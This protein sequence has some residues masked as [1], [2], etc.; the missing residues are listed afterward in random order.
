MT[1]RVTWLVGLD[2]KDDEDW[3]CM[4]TWTKRDLQVVLPVACRQQTKTEIHRWWNAHSLMRASFGRDELDDESTGTDEEADDIALDSSE[5]VVV[6]CASPGDCS[7]DSWSSCC[8]CCCRG[9]NGNRPNR[10]R[11]TG[12]RMARFCITANKADGMVYMNTPWKRGMGMGTKN[13]HIDSEGRQS[14]EWEC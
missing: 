13:K 7:C 9:G 4:L 1:S 3:N 2:G 12:L 11:I 5:L 10:C 8:C 14:G 6:V